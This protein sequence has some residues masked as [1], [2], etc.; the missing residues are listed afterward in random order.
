MG[1]PGLYEDS[2]MKS[3]AEGATPGLNG[4]VNS[5]TA[6]RGSRVT[7]GGVAAHDMALGNTGG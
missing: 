6:G 1:R 7:A 2:V 4:L 3:Y 5:G